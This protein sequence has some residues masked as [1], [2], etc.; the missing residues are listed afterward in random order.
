M[1]GANFG[2]GRITSDA[3]VGKWHETDVQWLP[4]SGPLTSGLPTLA[5]E[6]TGAFQT[7]FRGAPKVGS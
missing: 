3:N 2:T 4:G 5:A 1:M 7:Q 6:G